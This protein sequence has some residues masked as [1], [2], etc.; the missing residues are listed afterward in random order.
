MI[1]E[2]SYMTN[3]HMIRIAMH[4]K[5]PEKALDDQKEIIQGRKDTIFMV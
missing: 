1:Y 3:T 2:K 4:P 5:D